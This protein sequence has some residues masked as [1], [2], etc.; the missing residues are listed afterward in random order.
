MNGIRRFFS[1]FRLFCRALP[2]V[3]GVAIILAGVFPA[4]ATHV[5]HFVNDHAHLT[6]MNDHAGPAEKKAQDHE[7]HAICGPGVGC[8]AFTVPAEETSA[9]APFSAVFGR[10]DTV[11]LVTRIVAPPLPPPKII[12]PV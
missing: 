12:V 11:Q 6:T 8:L 10:F 1:T 3:L 2:I 4:T 9:F 7:D 5:G